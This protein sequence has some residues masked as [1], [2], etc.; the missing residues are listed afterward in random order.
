MEA[1]RKMV[2]EVGGYLT[3]RG[4]GTGTTTTTTKAA[5]NTTTTSLTTPTRDFQHYSSPTA[6]VPSAS[7]PL[8]TKRMHGNSYQSQKGKKNK[9]SVA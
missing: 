9:S 7:Q 2:N 6:Y 4:L 8:K 1:A 5:T 3:G